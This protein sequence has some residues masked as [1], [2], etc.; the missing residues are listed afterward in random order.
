[1]IALTS[2]IDDR[3]DSEIVEVEENG[4]VVR[5][6]DQPGFFVVVQDR[7]EYEAQKTLRTQG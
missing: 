3:L 5:L 7:D 6:Y 1:M 2:E 4:N